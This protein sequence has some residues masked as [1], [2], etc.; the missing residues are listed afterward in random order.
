M[1]TTWC[2]VLT[3]HSNFDSLPQ[4]GMHVWPHPASG[5]HACVAP[6]CLRQ[7]CMCGPILPQAG[8]RVAPSCLAMSGQNL[9]PPL[10]DLP[11][12]YILLHSPTR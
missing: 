6:S 5:R 3:I 2:H 1:L 11:P 4:A 9:P 10:Q 7:A 8:T 12:T